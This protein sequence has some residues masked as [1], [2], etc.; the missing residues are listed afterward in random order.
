MNNKKKLYEIK[1]KV[2]LALIN[3]NKYCWENFDETY[4]DKKGLTTYSEDR[5]WTKQYL[6]AMGLLE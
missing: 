2:Y 5:E 6:K 4:F 3:E 1:S